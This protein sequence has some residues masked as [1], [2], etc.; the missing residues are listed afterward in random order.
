ME[1]YINETTAALLTTYAMRLAGVIVLLFIAWI[2]AG[3]TWRASQRGLERA[4]SIP[5]CG[6]S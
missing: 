2:V 6:S 1:N 5:R 4:W 3:W